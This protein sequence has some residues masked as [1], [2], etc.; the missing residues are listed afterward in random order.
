M[1][2]AF[3][4]DASIRLASVFYTLIL[5]VFFLYFLYKRKMWARIL[6]LV[7]AYAKVIKFFAIIPAGVLEGRYSFSQPIIITD[8]LMVILYIGLIIILHRKATVAYFKIATEN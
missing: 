6:L 3:S 7:L 4:L 8:I 1:L 5:V 2:L